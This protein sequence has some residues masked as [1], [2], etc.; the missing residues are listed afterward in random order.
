MC[1][2]T[3][4]TLPE[5]APTSLITHTTKTVTI[6]V[7][8]VMSPPPAQFASNVSNNATHAGN[9][10]IIN[11]AAHRRCVL[12]VMRWVTRRMSVWPCSMIPYKLTYQ[13]LPQLPTLKCPLPH[14]ALLKLLEQRQL[15]PTLRTVSLWYLRDE[16]EEVE[17]AGTEAVMVEVELAVVV[18]Q[19]DAQVDER[20]DE[21]GV[22]VA[23]RPPHPRNVQLPPPPLM[24]LP[25]RVKLSVKKAVVVKQPRKLTPPL[26]LIL[27]TMMTT[28]MTLLQLHTHE[29]VN[30]GEHPV[31]PI[32]STRLPRMT[33]MKRLQ[34]LLTHPRHRKPVLLPLSS[35]HQSLHPPPPHWQQAQAPIPVLQHQLREPRPP[36][37]QLPLV[38][39]RTQNYILPFS[40]RQCTGY[41]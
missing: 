18:P 14:L 37:S 7:T 15:S 22:L 16:V 9:V 1:A 41:E 13:P 20:V 29:F 36:L 12:S 38:R 35:L 3:S 21:V 23:A 28:L 40:L 31:L 26:S 6:V 19:L 8:W 24:A 27:V 34:P 33:L 32:P 2:L 25:R 17:V 4:P 39:I 11:T 30:N 10:G 5:S